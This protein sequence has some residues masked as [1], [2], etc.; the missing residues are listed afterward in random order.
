MWP[1]RVSNP[2]PLA[3]ETDA[4]LT[5]LC[6]LALYLFDSLYLK[7]LIHYISNYSYLKVKMETLELSD[8]ET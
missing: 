5:G 2:G 7:L 1:Y 3:L 8:K 6:G 4:L